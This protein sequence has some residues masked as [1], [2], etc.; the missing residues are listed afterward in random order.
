MVKQ[1]IGYINLGN[2]PQQRN[3]EGKLICLN[4]SKLLK[5]RQQ[6]YCGWDCTEEWTCKHSHGWRRS[7]LARQKKYICD[8]CKT[9]CRDY[10][11]LDHIKPIALGGEEFDEKNLQILCKKCDKIK[12]KQDHKDIAKLRSIEKK[13]ADGQIQLTEQSPGSSNRLKPVVSSGQRL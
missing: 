9:D 6:K 8:K 3:S 12:T 4:C 10:Y 5:G 1:R 2:F 11:I 13:L 7:K